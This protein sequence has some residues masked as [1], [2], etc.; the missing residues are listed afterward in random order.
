LKLENESP[1][2]VHF[3]PDVVW[4]LKLQWQNHFEDLDFYSRDSILKE[5]SQELQ[6]ELT[7]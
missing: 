7:L 2:P 6:M 1:F 5:M 4:D 3:A